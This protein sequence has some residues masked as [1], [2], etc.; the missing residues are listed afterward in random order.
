M[1]P[2]RTINTWGGPAAG[3]TAPAADGSF[4]RRPRRAGRWTGLG[5]P[6]VLAALLVAL[7][8][9]GCQYLDPPHSLF[10]SPAPAQDDWDHRR[11]FGVPETENLQSP[12]QD[13]RQPDPQPNRP[14]RAALSRAPG[15]EFPH[16]PPAVSM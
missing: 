9:A 10:D 1:N 2:L 15:L 16:L 12:A 4:A 13:G 14:A 7:S 11:D 6:R 5:S 8:G 3:G